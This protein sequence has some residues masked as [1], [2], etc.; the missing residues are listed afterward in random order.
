MVHDSLFLFLHYLPSH[1]LSTQYKP[2]EGQ[3][4][5]RPKRCDIKNKFEDNSPNINIH[6][7]YLKY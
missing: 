6:Y 1:I 7:L 4:E 5:Q 2:N 3:K